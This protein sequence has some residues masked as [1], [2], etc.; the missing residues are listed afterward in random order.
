MVSIGNSS[1]KLDA[2]KAICWRSGSVSKAIIKWLLRITGVCSADAN[3]HA[4]SNNF[5]IDFAKIGVRVFPLGNEAIV[6]FK[7]LV[8]A[9]EEILF[10]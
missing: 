5:T 3:N 4:C 7:S 9:S 8:K 2:R 1:N 6:S 10:F